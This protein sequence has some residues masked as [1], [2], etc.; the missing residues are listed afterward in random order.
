M[1]DVSDQSV[2]PR[3]ASARGLFAGWFA[4]RLAMVASAGL[5]F[6]ATFLFLGHEIASLK[7][8]LLP[9]IVFL[10][11]YLILVSLNMVWVAKSVSSVDRPAWPRADALRRL[12]FP[13]LA[14]G[15]LG[16]GIL[17]AILYVH[18]VAK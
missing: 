6:I 10:P 16:F 2:S 7:N 13:A 15:G 11:A 18:G 8:E 1:L 14:L 5:G 3:P 9:L 12:R 17:A 4:G